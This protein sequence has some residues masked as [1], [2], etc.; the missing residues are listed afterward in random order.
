[1]PFHT[2]E[3]QQVT[4][5]TEFSSLCFLQNKFPACGITHSFLITFP[6][7]FWS[8]MKLNVKGKGKCYI[9]DGFIF[10]YIYVRSTQ[11][12]R[13]RLAIRCKDY[14]SVG[15]QPISYRVWWTNEILQLKACCRFLW[16]LQSLL[17]FANIS[18]LLLC[19]PYEYKYHHKICFQYT[20]G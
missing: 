19:S 20:F 13:L 6:Y 5:I 12:G 2:Y 9:H 4:E 3:L 1:M 7:Y 15:K 18:T 14:P 16:I 8:I 17:C 10:C 11:S